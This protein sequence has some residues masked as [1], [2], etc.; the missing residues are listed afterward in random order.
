[1]KRIVRAGLL[2][3]LLLSVLVGCGND[4]AEKEEPMRQAEVKD[5]PTVVNS[6]ASADEAKLASWSSRER[7]EELLAGMGIG[8][9]VDAKRGR[10]IVV[11]TRRFPVKGE[12]RDESSEVKESYDFP[13][14][15]NDDCET[16]RFKTAWKAYADGLADIARMIGET[17]KSETGN[18][19]ETKSIQVAA[20]LRLD[21]VVTVTT[22]ESLDAKNEEYEFSV[23]VCQSE[24]RKKAYKDYMSGSRVISPGRLSL[25]EWIDEK[26]HTGIIC[27]QSFI[28]N[29]GVWWRVAGVPVEV[30]GRSGKK[31]AV[32]VERAKHY[33]FEAA[34]RTMSVKVSS[35]M[36]LSSFSKNVGGVEELLER[37]ERKV[38]ISPICKISQSDFPRVKWFEKEQTSFIT[39]KRIRL[40]ICA[41]CELPS[42]AHA[43]QSG[44]GDSSVARGNS[45]KE[46]AYAFLAQRKWRTGPEFIKEAKFAVALGGASFK[47][48]SQMD[49]ADFAKK[50]YEATRQ[51]LM[52]AAM[53]VA[54]TYPV[55]GQVDDI[56]QDGQT[57]NRARR[58]FLN[59]DAFSVL[60]GDMLSFCDDAVAIRDVQTARSGWRMDVS[61]VGKSNGVVNEGALRVRMVKVTS[62]MPLLGLSVV[63]QFESLIDDVYQVVF[64]VT[65]RP[66][67]GAKEITSFDREGRVSADVG[68]LSLPEWIEAQDFGLMAGPRKYIDNEGTLW[69]IGI[70]PS[71]EWQ[72]PFGS[73]LGRLAHEC[74]AFALG[75]ELMAK[76]EYDSVSHASGVYTDR[77]AAIECEAAL[78][79]YP[80]EQESCFHRSFTHPL[81][82]R[83]GVVA[84]CAL[85]QGYS[86]LQ[87][88]QMV[89]ELEMIK[90]DKLEQ[91]R[92]DAMRNAMKSLEE[93]SAK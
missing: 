71:A 53:N 52:E 79:S 89:K 46:Q 6:V 17:V 83:K 12:D 9:G 33:A 8:M 29:E 28:D 63:R 54:F 20:G 30:E 58:T 5:P 4:D 26:S 92:Q 84:I 78:K 31:I 40:M 72:R 19:G 62:K 60:G 41:I 36:S 81:T 13:D 32:G 23:A 50:R 10:I 1:M 91:G 76:Y 42:N 34:I 16:R 21:G 74:A 77:K 25:K 18:D 2:F 7:V 87:R 14:D 73:S 68:K 15:E 11:E 55:E 90:Q 45:A 27:P 57:E 44:V 3:S 67:D 59:E 69:A 93:E 51:A 47:Y 66:Q 37:I 80:Q 22:A 75:G 65:H 43:L 82:G 85:R 38:E 70:V 88:R 39:G 35:F 24:K 48:N 61:S 56:F 64:V 86:D 49:D